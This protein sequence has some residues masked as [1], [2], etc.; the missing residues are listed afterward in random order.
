MYVI[1]FISSVQPFLAATCALFH[2]LLQQFNP[3]FKHYRY[4]NITLLKQV[5]YK[6][7]SCSISL[8]IYLFLSLPSPS[9]VLSTFSFPPH[10]LSHIL[11]HFLT[12]LI[13]SRH[14]NW[15]NLEKL[16]QRRWLKGKTYH[17][18]VIDC[19]ERIFMCHF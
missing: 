5:L 4:D 19:G 17:A 8:F 14:K 1:T 11:I 10:S 7:I 18:R 16:L 9:L 15:M 12:A 6:L 3:C 13:L 2:F